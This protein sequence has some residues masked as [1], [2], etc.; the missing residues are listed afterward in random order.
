[1]FETDAAVSTQKQ[2]RFGFIRCRTEIQTLLTTHHTPSCAIGVCF[3]CLIVA[4]WNWLVLHK[5]S[6]I[7]LPVN[8]K[9]IQDITIEESVISRI[10]TTHDIHSILES[11]RHMSGLI[12]RR[13]KFI[14]SLFFAQIIHSVR[15]ARR[16]PKIS[17]LRSCRWTETR[18]YKLT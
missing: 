8:R 15:G 16:I 11:V 1:M 13:L 2:T 9:S 14:L 3:T 6:A 18:A 12:L 4:M 10:R 7:V 17:T 5:S